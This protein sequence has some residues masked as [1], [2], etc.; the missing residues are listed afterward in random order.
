[1]MATVT[2]IPKSSLVLGIIFM[3]IFTLIWYYLLN[4]NNSDDDTMDD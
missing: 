3:F 2:R 1:M 4:K